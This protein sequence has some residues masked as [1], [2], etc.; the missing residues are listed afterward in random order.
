MIQKIDEPLWI[1]K[2]EIDP[3][4]KNTKPMKTRAKRGSPFHFWEGKY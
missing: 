2:T 1:N 3:L 4:K